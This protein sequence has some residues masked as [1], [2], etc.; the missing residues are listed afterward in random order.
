MRSDCAWT[1][2][3]SEVSR[4]E[5][6]RVGGES[7]RVT[8]SAELQRVGG[9]DG[10]ADMETNDGTERHTSTERMSERVVVVS[11]AHRLPRDRLESRLRCRGRQM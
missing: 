9:A 7:S 5:S 11:L 4:V 1:R 8:G 10:T 6:S 2:V 3:S